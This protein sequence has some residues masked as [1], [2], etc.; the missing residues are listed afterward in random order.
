MRVGLISCCKEKLDHKAPAEELYCS[1]LF[2]LSKQWIIK[3]VKEWGILSAQYGLVMPSRV[4]EPYDLALHELKPV[5]RERWADMVHK[6]LMTQWGDTPIYMI[7]AGADYR[8]AV[9]VLR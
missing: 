7:L 3:R 8:D 1:Q 9:G 5:H 4:I 2:K 6:Q